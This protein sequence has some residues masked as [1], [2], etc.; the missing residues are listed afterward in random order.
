MR[1]R[2]VGRA[3]WKIGP[4]PWVREAL[5]LDGVFEIQRRTQPDIWRSVLFAAVS[6]ASRRISALARVNKWV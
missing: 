3:I 4:G 6:L 1:R 2:R 5:L